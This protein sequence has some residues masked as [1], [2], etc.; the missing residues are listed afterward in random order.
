MKLAI[1]DLDNTLLDGDSDH[2][3]GEYI[4][5]I[6]LVDPAYYKK[7]NDQFYQDYLDGT[8]D[9]IAYQEFCLKT[10]T[11]HPKTKLESIRAE[12]IQQKI[13]PMVLDQAKATVEHH[14]NQKHEL[15]IIT[16][17]NRFITEPIA[18]LFNIKNLIA[19]EPEI[20]DH[21]Y[22]GKVSGTP[23]FGKGKIERLQLWLKNQGKTFS[24]T[25]FYSDSHNDIPLLENVDEAIAVNADEQLNRYAKERNWK[26]V[27]FRNL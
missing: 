26:I 5:E 15:L 24:Y 21:Q 7:Q 22:T 12:F 4:S 10:L 27:N 18:E 13:C 17:T 6:E 11:E 8:L 1:F 9:I 19:T 16:A 14:R 2:A 23:S 25:Y 20:V 3:W